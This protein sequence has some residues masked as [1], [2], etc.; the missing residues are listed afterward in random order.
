MTKLKKEKTIIYLPDTQAMGF[1]VSE[2]NMTW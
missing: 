1:T 2:E